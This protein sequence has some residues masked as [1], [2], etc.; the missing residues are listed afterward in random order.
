MRVVSFM[1][2]PTP[3]L[4]R[5]SDPMIDSVAGAIVKPTPAPRTQSRGRPIH[6]RLGQALPGPAVARAAANNSAPD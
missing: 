1:A 3:A 5:G 4:A 2:E 6:D